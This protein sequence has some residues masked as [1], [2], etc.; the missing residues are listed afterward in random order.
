MGSSSEL[1]TVKG[2]AAKLR[3]KVSW[4]RTAKGR[5]PIA[6]DHKKGLFQGHETRPGGI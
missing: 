6:L 3:V 2:I 5:L 4:V 1:L